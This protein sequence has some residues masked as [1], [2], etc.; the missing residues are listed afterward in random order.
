MNIFK[1]VI[2]ALLCD[3]STYTKLEAGWKWL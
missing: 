1:E 3:F 2:L